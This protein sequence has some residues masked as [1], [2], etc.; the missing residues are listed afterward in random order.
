MYV[1]REE[2]G[3]VRLEDILS[4]AQKACSVPNNRNPYLCLDLTYM[5][6]LLSDGYGL[7]PETK[8]NVKAMQHF[9][10]ILKLN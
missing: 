5:H 10:H 1:E 3:Q 9:N 7:Y 8:I 6:V 4:S 2:G